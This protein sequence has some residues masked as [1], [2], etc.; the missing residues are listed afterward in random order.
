M[1]TWPDNK[2]A[3][4]HI[5]RTGGTSL[6]EH[7]KNM[8]NK[9]KI[10]KKEKLHEPLNVKMQLTNVQDYTILTPIRHPLARI[11]SLWHWSKVNP[12]KRYK[13]LRKL[14]KLPF[15][16][17]VQYYCEHM[18]SYDNWLL[19]DGKLPSNIKFIRLENL[20]EDLEEIV[21][22]DS[23]PHI[24]KTDHEPPEQYYTVEL[25]QLVYEKEQWIFS[26]GVYRR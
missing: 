1:I 22:T 5:P 3:V 19:I 6:S 18:L 10:I 7:L 8:N 26:Q 15:G 2:L 12:D 24:Y 13:Y 21:N 4:F 20:L 11:V 16:D 14:A 17:F 9:Y 25:K 23:Y